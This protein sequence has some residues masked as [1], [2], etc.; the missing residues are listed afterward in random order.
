MAGKEWQ[1]ELILH[2]TVH[3]Q[4]GY[5]YSFSKRQ[6]SS[7][8]TAHAPFPDG[9]QKNSICFL[10]KTS[11]YLPGSGITS[12]H[13]TISR[14]KKS[15]GIVSLQRNQR[16]PLQLTHQNTINQIE[17]YSPREG[18]E[19]RN[20]LGYSPENPIKSPNWKP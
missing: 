14:K 12:S 1:G 8:R 16:F 6:V 4:C 20:T 11:S 13:K 7:S 19:N 15:H 9:F 17:E 5:I 10:S 2:G 18:T 3:G